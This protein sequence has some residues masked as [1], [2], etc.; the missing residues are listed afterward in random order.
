MLTKL[1]I[2]N[3]A[4][5]DSLDLCFQDGFTI[6]TG[7]TGAGK[8]LLIDSLHLILGE[9]ADRTLIKSGAEKAYVEAVFVCPPEM[10]REALPEEER[11]D[12]EIILSRELTQ[13]GRNVCRINGRLSSLAFLKEMAASLV[14]I[15]GQ[16]EH[17][18][19]FDAERHV[20]FL[21][22]Y[23]TEQIPWL[24]KEVKETYEA[25][26][27]INHQ[28][29]TEIGTEAERLQKIDLLTAQINEMEEANLQTEEEQEL[30]EERNVLANAENIQAVLQQSLLLLNGDDENDAILQNL[31]SAEKQMDTIATMGASF[32]TLRDR[33]NEQ[34]YQ[35]ED[36]FF[37]IRAVS[38]DIEFDPYRYDEIEQRLELISKLK[39]K[40]GADISEIRL[41]Q[42]RAQKEL[43]RIESLQSLAEQG[44]EEL[45][46]RAQS[47]YES[48]KKLHEVRQ[49]VAKKLEKDLLEQLHD[50]GMEKARFEIEFAAF[51]KYKEKMKF[52]ENG[53]D[54]V[55]MMLS[56]NPGEVLKP[57][58]KVAS[59][60]ELSR[61]MLAFKSLMVN[62]QS[63]ITMVFDEI[64]T[65]ISGRISSVVG[66]KMESIARNNQVICV[67]H[68]PQIA[69]MADTHYLIEKTQEK[70]RT[71]TTVRRLHEE[72]HI[73]EIARIAGGKNLSEQTVAYAHDLIQTA[74]SR[75]ERENEN[76]NH[77]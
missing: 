24:K 68:S 7:E 37:E 74:Q 63:M 8:S 29:T 75:K 59:G 43:E 23:D 5:I 34:F 49:K 1:H 26:Y 18:Q 58:Q 12:D 76:I 62:D 45:K 28:L 10:N 77:E 66:E 73:L 31:R 20:D 30:N 4:L 38:E 33:L 13:A 25:W 55:E 3:I 46:K 57:L 53:L 56:T 9:R 16:H 14:D 36:L 42:E 32:E 47:A 39:R 70:N 48:A 50:L 51:P 27:K 11:Q 15:Y 19:L 65:G 52:L 61:I 41:F 60:G 2:E 71:F 64:D 69:A 21:D 22:R 35:L 72:E 67:T 54:H 40:Y 17:Q 44:E 6:L